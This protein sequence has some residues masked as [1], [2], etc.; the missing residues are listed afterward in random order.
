MLTV[1]NIDMNVLRANIQ[2]RIADLPNLIKLHYNLLYYEKKL[3]S[4]NYHLFAVFSS[5]R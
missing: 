3:L 2:A 4:V 1:W 5:M